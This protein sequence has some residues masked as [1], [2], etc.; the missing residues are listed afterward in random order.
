MASVKT[1]DD[2]RTVLSIDP[3][4]NF[5]REKVAPNCPHMADMFSVFEQ[6]VLETPELQ[7]DIDHPELAARHTD[8]LMPLMSVAFPSSTWETE[9][10]GAFTPFQHTAVYLTPAY[11]RLLLDSRGQIAGRIKGENNTLVFQ[12]TI[13][14]Y[15]LIL[16]RIYGIEEGLSSPLVRI[17][18][19]PATGLE[20]YFQIT[21]DFQFVQVGTVGA[22][23]RSLIAS[24]SR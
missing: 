15:A 23:R 6:R 1:V 24:V 9:V 5:W 2:F 3:L 21:P 13:R 8:I 18:T 16:E 10:A 11:Q 4:L 7:G 14:A 12:R 22:P 17:V 20:R 19:D